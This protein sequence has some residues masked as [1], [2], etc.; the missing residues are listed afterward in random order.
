MF[1]SPLELSKICRKYS[2]KLIL[3]LVDKFSGYIFTDFIK[4]TILDQDG[5]TIKRTFVRKTKIVDNF[6][7]IEVIDKSLFNVGDKFTLNRNPSIFKILKCENDK[8]FIDKD[9]FNL[10]IDNLDNAEI[11]ENKDCINKNYTCSADY[12][13]SE[14]YPYLNSINLHC[15]KKIKSLTDYFRKNIRQN[16]ICKKEFDNLS[17]NFSDV[18][19]PVVETMIGS[20]IASEIIKV[21]GKYI[22]IEQ[23]LIIDYSEFLKIKDQ[24][25]YY[26]TIPDKSNKS[27]YKLLTKEMIKYLKKMNVFLVGSGAL[28]CEYLKLFHMLNISTNKYKSKNKYGPSGCITLTDMDTIELSN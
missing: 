17:T 26:K 19:F 27:L 18:R 6:V 12:L 11:I 20:I 7:C 1:N 3:G 2:T 21:T 5:E 24:S 14:N 13:N 16:K 28:G 15:E 23:E 4:H 9:S 10:S 22:P 8:I 25:L